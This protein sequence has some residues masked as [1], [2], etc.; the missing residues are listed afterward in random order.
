MPRRPRAKPAMPQ[1]WCW[2]TARYLEEK[3]CKVTVA[4]EI[5]LAGHLCL[6]S[7][8]LAVFS[9]TVKASRLIV[10]LVNLGAEF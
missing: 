4:A 2:M 9:L 1:P 6:L 7:I 3:A 10:N 8:L 5:L